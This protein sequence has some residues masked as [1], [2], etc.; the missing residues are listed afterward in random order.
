MT[1]YRTR[2][3]GFFICPFYYLTGLLLEKLLLTIIYF[4]KV[5]NNWHLFQDQ[6]LFNYIFTHHFVDKEVIWHAHHTHTHTQRPKHSHHTT[7]TH[8]HTH[9]RNFQEIQRGSGWTIDRPWGKALAWAE[10]EFTQISVRWS[11]DDPS[12]PMQTWW[13][14]QRSTRA[15]AVNVA[16]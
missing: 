4:A 9:T 14:G 3:R 6:F 1:I 2:T 16:L 13:A 10:T 12:Q 7:H 8:T 5:K 15:M 11:K